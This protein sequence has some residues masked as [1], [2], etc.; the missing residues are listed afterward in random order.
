[1]WRR[2]S[3]PRGDIEPVGDVRFLLQRGCRASRGR[4]RCRFPSSR[5]HPVTLP[6][7]RVGWQHHPMPLFSLIV[8]GPIHLRPTDPQPSQT[9]RH[10]FLI[11]AHL[12][13]PSQTSAHLARPLP[14]RQP[15]E[16]IPRSHLQQHPLPI[17]QQLLHVGP[18]PHRLPHVPY[19]VVRVPRFLL[20]DPRPTYIRQ[21]PLARR[22]QLHPLQYSSKFFQHPVHHP[23]MK[24]MRSLEPPPFHPSL[25]QP[26]LQ[27]RHPLL[28]S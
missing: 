6:F 24:R 12:L 16:H 20:P 7:K 26:L 11:R 15:P 3:F 1:M 25:P 21:I 19:P 9:P 8:Y 23:R 5:F 10:P 2:G 22:L 27:L 17:S 4:C 13:R 14:P 28:S 18:K